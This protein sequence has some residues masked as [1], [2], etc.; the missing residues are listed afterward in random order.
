MIS[1][2]RYILPVTMTLMSL[3]CSSPD[4]R[5]GRLINADFGLESGDLLFQDLDG[6]PYIAAIEAVTVGWRGAEFAHVGIVDIAE[7]GAVMVIEALPENGVVSTPIDIFLGRSHDHAGRPKVVVGR[8]TKQ[9]RQIASAAIARAK[10]RIGRP[11]DPAFVA[12][13]D[14]WYCSELVHDVYRELKSGDTVFQLEPMTFID[15]VSGRTFEIWEDYFAKL[16]IDVPEGRPGINPGAL[17]RSLR[18]TIVH[19]YGQPDGVR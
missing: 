2:M 4:V 15:P 1:A 18:I 19:M 6:G 5:E 16:K 17:S 7:G 3:A 12:G 8:M 14:A 9:S 11:Y 10:S 13:D